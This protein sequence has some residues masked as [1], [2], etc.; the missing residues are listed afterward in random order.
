M[1]DR[2][3]LVAKGFIHIPGV[4]YQEIFSPVIRHSTLRLFFAL[5]VQFGVGVIHLDVTTTVYNDQLKENIFMHLPQVTKLL[6]R[7]TKF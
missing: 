4:D 3:R 2:V 7:I 1:R 5:S 6:I